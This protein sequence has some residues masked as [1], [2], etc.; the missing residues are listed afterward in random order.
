MITPIK[1]KSTLETSLGVRLS[2]VSSC[3]AS[4]F[5]Y[6]HVNNCLIL[7]QTLNL[8]VIITTEGLVQHRLVAISSAAL[9]GFAMVAS[10][11]L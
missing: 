1:F 5:F 2:L 3:N 6:C 8:A 11:A 9:S 10:E 7:S 4:G